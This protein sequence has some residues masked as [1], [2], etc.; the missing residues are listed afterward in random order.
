MKKITKIFACVLLSTALA[1]TAI[2]VYAVTY[3]SEDDPLIS[4]SYVNEVLLPQVKEMIETYLGGGDISGVV[5]PNPAEG[6]TEEPDVTTTEPEETTTEPEVTTTE[7]EET[8]EEP[9]ETTA[10]PEEVFPSGTV[11]TGSRYA[12]VNLAA[13]QTIYA[14]VYSCEVIVRSGS[15]KVVSPFTVKWEE[16]GVSDVTDGTEIYNEGAVPTNH[17]IIIPRDDGRGITAL[18][19]GAWIMVRGDY[20]IKDAET[21]SE[22]SAVEG[23]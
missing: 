11:N 3:S 6:T 10:E 2:C 14:S 1:F 21:V 4:L 12:V 17:T 22:T 9:E 23:E 7:P 18:E 19:G 20:I 8:T 13:G 16:Q 15:T 5:M